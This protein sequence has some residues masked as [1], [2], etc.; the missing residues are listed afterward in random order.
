S[1]VARGHDDASGERTQPVHPDDLQIRAEVVPTGATGPAAAAG[2]LRVDRDEPP[3]PPRIH[4][5]AEL[6]HGAGEL[7]AADVTG[8][9]RAHRAAVRA[10]VRA[11]DSRQRHL[12]H[13]LAWPRGRLGKLA[14]AHRA[15]AVP[16][17]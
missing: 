13:G 10:H 7:V 16:A 9:G 1:E 5:W 2:D 4:P 14:D 3:A 12:D 17:Q 11:A 8:A 6:G 15:R